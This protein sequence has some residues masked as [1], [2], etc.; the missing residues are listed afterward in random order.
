ML[1]NHRI[2]YGL[3]TVSMTHHKV[4]DVGEGGGNHDPIISA[5]PNSEFRKVSSKAW[6]GVQTINS[7]PQL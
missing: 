1:L 3:T 5:V 7:L 4:D 2:G 6:V